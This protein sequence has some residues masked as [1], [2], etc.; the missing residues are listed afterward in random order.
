MGRGAD[1]LNVDSPDEEWEE[2]WQ[3]MG[4]L[5]WVVG[6]AGQVLPEEAALI[7]HQLAEAAT[8]CW[9]RSI[10]I[11]AANWSRPSRSPS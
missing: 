3:E 7:E 9:L 10:E 1:Q 5:E 4:R 2:A 6:V 8:S 11:I